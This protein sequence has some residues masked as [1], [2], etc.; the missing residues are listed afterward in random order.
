MQ[1]GEHHS[2]GVGEERVEDVLRLDLLMVPHGG[3]LVRLLQ[4]HLGLDRQPVEVHPSPTILSSS[5]RVT[6]SP[7][8]PRA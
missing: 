6:V 5:S 7:T 8:S 3:L 1:E 4:R 2:L